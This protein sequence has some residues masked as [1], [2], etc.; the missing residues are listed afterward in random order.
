MKTKLLLISLVFLFSSFCFSEDS[1]SIDRKVNNDFLD[2]M[3]DNKHQ[4]V[5]KRNLKLL[6]QIV[7]RYKEKYKNNEKGFVEFIN[8]Q[9]KEGKAILIEPIIREYTEMIEY[10]LESGVDPNKPDKYGETSLHYVA[11]YGNVK[12][13][14]LLYKYG[15][16]QSENHLGRTPLDIAEHKFNTSNAFKEKHQK[17]VEFLSGKAASTKCA[18]AISSI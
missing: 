13:A 9:D 4:V 3:A 12:A 11:Y 8:S 15:A 1:D 7:E 17:M 5:E 2:W 16:I 14:E 6:K 18:S 10:I